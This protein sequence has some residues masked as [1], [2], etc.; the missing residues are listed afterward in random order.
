MRTRAY[1]AGLHD[2][3]KFSRHFQSKRLDLWPDALGVAPEGEIP[4][5]HWVLTGRML[6]DR[7][8]AWAL[9]AP[10]PKL[11]REDRL[12]LIAAIA[13]H[14]G[15]PPQV[16]QTERFQ[17]FEAD[18]LV[19]RAGL[20]AAAE[21]V[22]RLAEL[23]GPPP[24]DG[25]DMYEAAQAFS[26]S[27]SGLVTAADWVGSDAH[28]MPW[29]TP[30][31]ALDAYWA[32]ARAAAELA[33][34]GKGL[35]PSPAAAQPSLSRLFPAIAAPRP[36][37]RFAEEAPLGE[38]PVLAILEDATGSGKTEAALILAAR[39]MAAGKG[40]GV[41][42]ALPTMATADAMFARLSEAHL[43][44]FAE[45]ARPSIVLAHGRAA[46]S[47][48]FA[49][50]RA[51][52]RSA[53]REEVAAQCAEWLADDRR[54]AFLADIGAGTID[55]ALLA[56]L[57]KRF[58][59]LRQ[60]GLAGKILIIDEAHA[61]DRYMDEEIRTLLAFQAA[62][63]GSAIVLSATL[64]MAKRRDLARSFRRG[65]GGDA[66]SL[67][68]TEYPLATVVSGAGAQEAPVA[69]APTAR[70]PTAVERLGEEEAALARAVAAAEAGAAVLWV[71]NAV[72][73]AIRA[74]D[75]LRARG[76]IVDL[77]HARFAMV[78]RRRI[79]DGVV[80]RYGKEGDEEGRR[81]R[82]LVSTQV[83]ESSLDLDLDLLISDLAPVDSLIQRAGRIWRHMDRRPASARPLADPRLLLL[84]P[85]PERVESADWVHEIQEKGGYVYPDPGVL[86]RTARALL[87]AREI[88]APEGVRALIE[89][90]FAGDAET[91][92]PLARAEREARGRELAEEALARLNV[93]NRL[94][95]YGGA[96]GLHEDQEIGTRLGR[97]MAT[98]RL[99]VFDGRAVL[100]WASGEPDPMRA[101]AFS[102]ISV[103]KAWVEGEKSTLAPIAALTAPIET[104]KASWPEWER[105]AIRVA[106]VE[107]DGSVALEAADGARPLTYDRSTGLH[108][109][110]PAARG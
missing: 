4:G 81:G 30:E 102:E 47:E 28:A 109:I 37:Q 34:R 89:T 104:A 69:G 51:A 87:A 65:L 2:L 49:R 21:A 6:K 92:S 36:L 13:G 99:A 41:F 60:H 29:E 61:F 43:R 86:W 17:G 73:D 105:E 88:R 1:F 16:D 110:A 46:L 94:D 80:A 32:K 10:L 91:P 59:T 20:D 35:V 57:P 71:R 93:V 76:A 12:P 77:F 67:V 27:L 58:L 82:I 39:M 79:E 64:P 3:G 98:L 52:G 95:G 5:S 11:H 75:A 54:K 62:A 68:R 38:G 22:R 42:F 97:P 107:P 50:I 106:V 44:L 63:G 84:A 56:V 96:G 7:A 85:D 45:E 15:R 31:I 25:I 14:H 19:G 24:L 100:P 83:C 72:D 26:W 66:P 103:P 48:P 40:E 33:V 90:V 70:P 8:L 23:I 18:R 108:R 74:A 53:D 78:D 101:W 9:D 55:Q